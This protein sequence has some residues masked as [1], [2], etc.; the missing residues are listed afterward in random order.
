MRHAELGPL[1]DDEARQGH[2]VL[3]SRFIRSSAF[4]ARSCSSSAFVAAQP[5]EMI[6]LGSVPGGPFPQGP[7]VD[8]QV[9]GDLRDRLPGLPHDPN[10]TL[11]E[12]RIE[13]PACLWHDHP[14]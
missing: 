6:S 11:P 3:T 8:P 13:L 14:S 2:F 10:R 5:V 1:V 9:P 4:S 7:L 12:L